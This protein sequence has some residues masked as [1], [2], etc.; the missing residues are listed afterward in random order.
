M[1]RERVLALSRALA[2]AL[3]LSLV[4]RAVLFRFAIAPAMGIQ[5]SLTAWAMSS[6]WLG[7][8]ILTI[9]GL[10]GGRKWG[11]YS[12]TLLSPFS[13]LLMSVP[14]LPGIT[15]LVPDAARSY[16]MAF[17]NI[18][19]LAAVPILLKQDRRQVATVSQANGQL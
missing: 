9:A 3:C 19:V 8:V 16:A 2:I 15:T 1:L 5:T 6:A 14:L 17:A 11:A 12:L 13:T 7:L 18:A 4:E 10:A